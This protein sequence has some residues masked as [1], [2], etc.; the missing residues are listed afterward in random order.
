M[1]GEDEGG[2]GIHGAGADGDAADSPDEDASKTRHGTNKRRNQLIKSP[3]QLSNAPLLSLRSAWQPKRGSVNPKNRVVK[4]RGAWVE[5]GDKFAT[6]S[7]L[8]MTG[9]ETRRCTRKPTDW[10]LSCHTDL[11]AISFANGSVSQEQTLAPVNLVLAYLLK[12]KL[13]LSN[14]P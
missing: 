12:R 4:L 3:T 8:P 2:G 1:P 14:L 6:L 13:M 11:V 9:V 5:G 7:A 10:A